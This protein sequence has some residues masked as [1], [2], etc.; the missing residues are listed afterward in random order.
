MIVSD[1]NKASFFNIKLLHPLTEISGHE[2]VE[3]KITIQMDLLFS[4]LING[5]SSCIISLISS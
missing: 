5:K 1:N 4:A 3:E 2:S